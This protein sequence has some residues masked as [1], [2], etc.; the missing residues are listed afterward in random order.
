MI[1]L[2]HKHNMHHAYDLNLLFTFR[3]FNFGTYFCF[4]CFVTK[5]INIGGKNY[6]ALI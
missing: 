4:V 2:K 6:G 5:Y 1:D 3:L